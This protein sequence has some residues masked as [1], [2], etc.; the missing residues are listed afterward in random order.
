MMSQDQ[1]VSVFETV[2]AQFDR[3]AG[4]IG[5]DDEMQLLLKTPFREMKVE[6][7]IRRDDGSLG[8]WQG[9]RIQFNGSRGPFKGGIRYHHEVD[10]DEV[11]GLSALM[12]WK[13]AL[14]NIP[15][16]GGKGGITV[17]ARELSVYEL[18]RLTRKF[19][20]RIDHILGPYR[21]VPA[22]DV[23]TNAQVM[24]WI[25]DEYS[26]RHGY[27]PACVTGKPLAMGG[28]PGREAATGRGAA[29]VY[30][31]IARRE[32]WDPATMTVAIQGFGNVGSFAA[33]FMKEMGV[34]VLAISGS[35]G[36]Y[37]NGDGIDVEAASAYRREAGTLEGLGGVEEMTNEALLALDVDV[38]VPA[39]LG[40]AIH[41][42]NAANV[43][44]RVILEA[45][46]A[47]VTEEGEKILRDGGRVM[48]IPDVLASSGGVTV[49]YFEW[50][51]N[52]QQFRWDE[53]RVNG[54]LCKV[55]KRATAEVYA[56]AAEKQVSWRTAAFIVAI[57][58]IAE[59]ERLRGL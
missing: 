55:M 17:N 46:N 7:P 10:M 58:R 54:E 53:E 51:Q 21:D 31:E 24:A 48:L 5:L 44:A 39:A 4:F 57:E 14:V 38:L 22:P 36:A 34:K 30:E 16:G 41:A 8:V 25:F 56:L 47:P 37:F 28:S 27:A 50:V 40:G 20:A 19:I 3:A 43:K 23:N 29:M 52:I 33:R 59:A 6:L 32:G 9:Y 45:A 1:R 49:S 13:T 2:A 18:E 42:G 35:R 15:F 12:A 26:S 11:R